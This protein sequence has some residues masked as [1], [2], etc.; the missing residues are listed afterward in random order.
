[1]LSFGPAELVLPEATVRDE[2][3]LALLGDDE[4]VSVPAHGGGPLSS[5]E[6]DRAARK[7]G[8]TNVA[9]HT[10]RALRHV[11]AVLGHALPRLLV[12]IGMHESPRRWAGG[13]YRVT[14][15]S[16]D[17]PEPSPVA[18]TGEVHLGGGAGFLF[19][20]GGD[21]YFVAPSHNLAVIYH[22]IGHHICQHTA[23]FRLNRLR[24][25]SE[26][27]NKKIALDEGTSD[28]LTAIALNRPDIYRWHRS[29]IPTWDPRRRA[30]G[31]RWTMANFRGGRT[32]PHA[33]GTVWAS[34]CWTARERVAAAGADRAKFDRMLLIGLELSSAASEPRTYAGVDQQTLK[35]RRHVAHLLEAMLRADPELAEPV[36]SGM[37][38]HGIRPG[39]T[40]AQLREAAR[41]SRQVAVGE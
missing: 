34:A 4:F 22:E 20:P 1:V 37:A 14:A 32:D 23:D 36:R 26:Q 15:R 10:Q 19:M 6:R 35:Q 9:F 40:N 13:H 33:D 12:R 8:L 41:A 11:S 24:P 30:L 38:A 17:V 39:A 2:R 21:R 27:T 25:A 28:L 5:A 29:T 3:G 7:F 31:P 16:Y 18:A